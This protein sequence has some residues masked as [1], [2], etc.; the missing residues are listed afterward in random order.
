MLVGSKDRDATEA[1][2][3]VGAVLIALL[4]GVATPIDD[5]QKMRCSVV[6]KPVLADSGDHYATTVRVTFQRI[7]W[8]NKGK[9]SKVEKLDEPEIYV[10]FFDKLSKS[11][12]LEAHEI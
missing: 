10:E 12:F 6:T 9:I 3:V 1:G 5:T 7:V 4:F 8:D 2:Q 11:V